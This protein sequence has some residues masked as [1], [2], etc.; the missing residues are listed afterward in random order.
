MSL[1]FRA[2]SGAIRKWGEAKIGRKE[3]NEGLEKFLS[4]ASLEARKWQFWKPY[5]H[6]HSMCTILKE[7]DHVKYLKKC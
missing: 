7:A 4:H 3:N 2:L 5:P 1:V 6:V